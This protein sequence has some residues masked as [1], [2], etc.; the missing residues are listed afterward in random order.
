[1]RTLTIIVPVSR[2]AGKLENF[3][4]WIC[5][6]ENYDIQVIIVHDKQ[7]E[8]TTEE[9]QKIIRTIPREKIVYL[10][11]TVISPGLARNLGLVESNSKW[12]M[13]A[14][15]DDVVRIDETFK[16]INEAT[17]DKQVLV[18]GYSTIDL[19]D[20]HPIPKIQIAKSKIDLAINPGLWRVIFPSEIAKTHRFTS[21]RMAEDQE[22]LL[23]IGIFNRDLYFSKHIVY[24]YYQGIKGQLTSNSDAI[25]ELSEVIPITLTYLQKCDSERGIYVSVVVLRQV[26]TEL[27]YARVQAIQNVRVRVAS[28]IKLRNRKKLQLFVAVMIILWKK[29]IDG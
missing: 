1:M 2:M 28:I 7:D 27:K 12:V 13:F 26:F 17:H 15:S 24:T 19:N 9:V 5:E 14:D 25:T 11:K 3:K 22:Y 6:I 29:M 8:K 20:S 21:Y 4:S 16:L 18:G 10:E 23:G